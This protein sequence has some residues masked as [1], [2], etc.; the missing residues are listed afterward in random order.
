MA[1]RGQ[2]AGVPKDKSSEPAPST[3]S[4]ARQQPKLIKD[5]RTRHEREAY[6]QR[7]LLLAIGAVAAV[8]AVLLV[9]AFVVDRV[10]EPNQVA[11]TVNGQNITVGQ[12]QTQVRLTRALRNFEINNAVAQYQSFGIPDDQIQQF[13]TS[14]PPYSVWVNEFQVPDQ[15][16]NSVLNEM[17]E[18]ELIRQRAAELGITITDAD[19]EAQI[20]DFFGYDPEAILSTATPTAEPSVTPTPLV[21]P[22]ATPT[23]AATATLAATPT[24]EFTPVPS[25]T[26]EPTL[27]ATELADR[28]NTVRGDTFRA[29]QTAAGVSEADVRQHFADLALRAKLRDS[30]TAELSQTAPFVDVRVIVVDSED[31]ANDILAALQNGESFAELARANSSDASS[32]SG[33]ELGWSTLDSLT[34]SFGQAFSDAIA[35]AAVGELTGPIATESATFVIGQVRAREDRD[36]T[37]DEMESARDITFAEYLATLRDEADVSTTTNWVNNVPQQPPFVVSG[38]Q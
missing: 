12:F 18:T 4:T 27:N 9:V 5:Y 23:L 17:I 36:M 10:I 24:L 28:F 8:V 3:G 37:E 6:I 30:V 7:I 2:T 26:P 20:E 1:K 15:L 13:L 34:A 22:T 29:I 14:Q 11:A 35:A 16:G 25:S 31:N 38:L 33:G 32:G 19:V 21:S